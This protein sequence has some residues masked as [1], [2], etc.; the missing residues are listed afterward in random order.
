MTTKGAQILNRLDKTMIS[1]DYFLKLV[2]SRSLA[3]DI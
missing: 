2:Q 1:E 3:K